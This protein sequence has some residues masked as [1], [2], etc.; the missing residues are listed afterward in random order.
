MSKPFKE[1]VTPEQYANAKK[2][3]KALIY[4]NL[5]GNF[6]MQKYSNATIGS[7]VTEETKCGTC[8][9]SAGWIPFTLN[10]PARN[11]HTLGLVF[12]SINYISLVENFLG[13]DSTRLLISSLRYNLINSTQ[14]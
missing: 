9:C 2:H 1:L 5:P 11:I 8:A 12:K 7:I 13:I 10:I 6:D 4:G 14:I 3:W